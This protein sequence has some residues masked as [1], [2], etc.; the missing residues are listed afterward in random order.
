VIV[1][2]GKDSD[3]ARDVLKEFPFTFIENPQWSSGQASSIAE[4]V[5]T[6][7]PSIR[8]AFFFLGD[9]PRISSELVKHVISAWE[10]QPGDIF[11]PHFGEQR[12]NPVLFSKN[13][14]TRLLTLTGDQGGKG[15]FAAFNVTL[16]PWL[17]PDEFLDVDTQEDYRK[18]MEED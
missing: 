11:V 3:R 9:Q 8:A 18:L 10:T 15:I 4:G 17:R 13:T 16:V 2:L 5:N 1:V 14:F 7:L 12:G 6:L